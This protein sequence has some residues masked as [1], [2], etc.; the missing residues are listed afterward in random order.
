MKN[1]FTDPINFNN[2]IE[3]D[4]IKMLQLEFE[5]LKNGWVFVGSGKDRRVVCKNNVVI[6]LPVNN[7][8]LLAN[9]KEANLYKQTKSKRLAPCRLLK[10]GLLMMRKVSILNDM[11]PEDNEQ[12]PM[13]AYKMNDGAQVGIDSSGNVLAFDYAEDSKNKDFIRVL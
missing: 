8:G 1:S 5:L 3:H 6:K 4:Y 7:R 9:K 10:N 11:Y 2:S 13:W 12:I